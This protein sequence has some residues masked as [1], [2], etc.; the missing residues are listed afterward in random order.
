MHCLRLV[1]SRVFPT[2][3]AYYFVAH[4]GKPRCFVS[5]A[6]LPGSGMREKVKAFISLFL[7]YNRP[8]CAHRRR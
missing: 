1:S 2:P 5:S 7:C 6:V 4:S 8:Q 3:L